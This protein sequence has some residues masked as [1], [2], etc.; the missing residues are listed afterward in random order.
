M[1][2]DEVSSKFDRSEAVSS[3]P[4]PPCSTC[5]LEDPSHGARPGCAWPTSPLAPEQH[6]LPPAHQMYR[7][8]SQVPS[9]AALFLIRPP[10]GYP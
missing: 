6:T 3:S 1:K 10:C 5:K 9:P 8:P 2:Y 7:I 4:A